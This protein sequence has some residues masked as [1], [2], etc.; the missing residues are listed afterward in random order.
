MQI[1][2]KE[3]HETTL[4]AA[5]TCMQAWV[6]FQEQEADR[7]GCTPLTAETIVRLQGLLACA[8]RDAG[9]DLRPIITRDAQ[10]LEISFASV[11]GSD[12]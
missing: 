10:A 8:L 4:R 5:E 6:A 7:G 12:D 11:K 2:R 3:V 9:I 1:S